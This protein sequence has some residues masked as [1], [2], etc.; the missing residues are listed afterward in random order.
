M[1]LTT[2]VA[3]FALCF[4]WLVFAMV[5]VGMALLL[6]GLIMK[7]KVI[8]GFTWQVVPGR[9]L[10]WAGFA[11]TFALT[12]WVHLVVPINGVVTAAV[13]VVGLVGWVVF[14][15]VWLSS[16]HKVSRR[17][18]LWGF[19]LL[20]V[21]A[22]YVANQSLLPALSTDSYLYHFQMIRLAEQ[23]PQIFGIANV[24][25][26][27]GHG[28]GLGP[29]I[30]LVD[31]GPWQGLGHHLLAPL[32]LVGLAYEALSRSRSHGW[33][34]GV[35]V[36]SGWLALLFVSLLAVGPFYFRG[37]L[38][39]ESGSAYWLTSPNPD[40]FSLILIV[41]SGLYLIEA[42]I[43][44]QR[45]KVLIYGFIAILVVSPAAFIRPLN[46]VWLAL[47]GLVVL[48]VL[49]RSEFSDAPRNWLKPLLL[50]TGS[51]GVLLIVPLLITHLIVSGYFLYPL[52]IFSSSLFDW[53]VPIETTD[54]YRGVV[55]QWARDPNGA[56]EWFPIW[57][58]RTSMDVWSQAA[59]LLTVLVAAALVLGA[60]LNL[61]FRKNAW[62]YRRLFL[63]LSAIATTLCTWFL[64]GPDLRFAYGFIWLVP[65][66]LVS[67][68]VAAVTEIKHHRTVLATIYVSLALVV[69]FVLTAEPGGLSNLRLRE[70]NGSEFLGLPAL[71]IFPVT[72]QTNANGV[73][74]NV[75]TSGENCGAAEPPCGLG[76]DE[77]LAYRGDSAR[78]GFRIEDS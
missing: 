6:I 26:R 15:K 13:I 23:F 70:A 59:L 65:I 57:A 43:S 41:V 63:V 45:A 27:F 56:T 52:S 28:I 48:F 51:L 49:G 46:L 7:L 2:V 33:G 74:I 77:K 40:F 19:G 47:V 32:L 17:M 54:S 5:F 34:R 50:I 36:T 58:I 14:G 72:K 37:M 29:A 75:P 73:V 71:K 1:I 9:A 62:G 42:V 4:T 35:V 44:K 25:Y 39:G 3:M 12:Q 78:D 67:W 53:R 64:L 60:F 8:D 18:R 20:A 69:G 10:F 66:V 11:S 24:H 68:L 30:A 76:L 38:V 21:F 22:L 55:Q 16:Q 61:Q 31:V